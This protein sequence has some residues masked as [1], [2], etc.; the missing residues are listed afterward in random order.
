M[1]D[2][3]WYKSKTMYAAIAVAIIGVCQALGLELPYDVV[4]S[5]CGAFGLYGIRDAVGKLK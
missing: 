5:I 3:E 1:K 4:Y 2:K